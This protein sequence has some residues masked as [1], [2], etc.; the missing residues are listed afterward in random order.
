MCK[1]D[2]T[3]DCCHMV[4]HIAVDCCHMVGHIAGVQTP[5]ATQEEE[6][7]LPENINYWLTY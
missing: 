6:N 3:L 4:G 2:C 5:A 1:M 7:E